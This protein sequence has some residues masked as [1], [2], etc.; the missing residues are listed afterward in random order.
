MNQVRFRR[1]RRPD[2]T[3]F[4][5]VFIY[6]LA[7]L[8]VGWHQSGRMAEWFDNQALEREGRLSEAALVLARFLKEKVFPRGPAQLNFMEDALLG[9]LAPETEIGSVRPPAP[10]PDLRGEGGAETDR[11]PEAE[12]DRPPDLAALPPRAEPAWPDP[13]ADPDAWLSQVNPD[14]HLPGPEAALP[15]PEPAR[16]PSPPPPRF[17]KVLLLGDSMM[18]EGL[19]P[20]LQKELRRR[21]ENLTVERDGR[22]GT[23][24]T[25]LDYF[26]WL[27]FFEQML[28][29][30]S[31]DLVILTIGA[32]DPQDILEPEGPS[33]R[34]RILVGTDDWKELYAVRV[35]G[36]LKLAEDRGV[37]VFW[38]GLPIMGREP[39]GSRVADINDVAA[40]ACAGAANCR[41]WDSW[42]SMADAQG[43]FTSY[44]LDENGRRLRLRGRD[45][46]HLTEDGGRI[47]AQRFLSET[48]DWADYRA[49]EP[50]E[51]PEAAAEQPAAAEP[52]APVTAEPAAPVAAEPAAALPAEPLTAPLTP[53]GVPPL[54]PQRPSPELPG[55]APPP[56]AP[57]A[58]PQ[59]LP[60]WPPGDSYYDLPWPVS[61]EPEEGDSGPEPEEGDEE[62]F[63]DPLPVEDQAPGP[64][65]PESG[66]FPAPSAGDG[67][68]AWSEGLFYAPALG[69]E[70]VLRLAG[71]GRAG[72]FPLIL[73]LHGAWD[74]AAAWERELGRETLLALADRLEVILAMPEGG[75]FGW[76]LDGL[77]TAVETFILADFLPEALK[78]SAADP[79]RLAVAGLSMGGHG[80]LTLALKRPDLFQAAAALSAV[81]D[82]AAHAAGVPRANL[83]LAID[84]VLGP[85]GPAGRNWR[86]FGAAGLWEA[87]SGDWKGRP[88]FL[89]VGAADG[90]TLAENR[91][92]TRQLTRLGI[93]HVYREKPGGHDWGYWSAELPGLLEFLAQ[94]LHRRSGGEGT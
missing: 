27:G 86:P 80:A 83:E 46:I 66:L 34:R 12:A 72:T 93:E 73:L 82:L 64:R 81:T 14:E 28:A 41:F 15:E 22:Y 2:L 17:S 63:V 18:L 79:G 31:P 32:N 3:P 39:Y 38:V 37:R 92:F 71:P 47:M 85:A 43:R 42:L 8:M 48:E 30:Y 74:S 78:I 53:L 55:P 36:L 76:Y 87:R 68:A 5:A 45:F 91:A 54:P 7:F 94:A 21:H 20:Q 56:A 19:G 69:R 59:A 60:V 35:A 11:P 89:G 29:K 50:A 44:A 52:A 62:E 61:P 58:P 13:E 88:L 57:P 23:G 26:D 9:W 16:P 24:L 1:P 33:G 90:L 70:T 51:P 4:R 67:A 65:P 6:G 77:E 40:A 75:A 25:R 84:R 10:R 49:G